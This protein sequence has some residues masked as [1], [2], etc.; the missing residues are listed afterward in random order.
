MARRKVY[1]PALPPAMKKARAAAKRALKKAPATQAATVALV[2]SVIARQD[3]TKF[4]SELVSDRVGHN[5][6][7]GFADIIN[8]LPKLVQDQGEGA[9]YE[10]LG[11][12]VSTR[13]HE[14]CI[15]VCMA[16]VERSNNIIVHMWILTNKS[17]KQFN[18]LDATN[19]NLARLL[20]LGSTAQ[21][22]SYNGYAQDAMLPINSSQFTVLHHR[23]FFLGKNTGTLQ[24]STT[25]GNQPS[26]THALNKRFTF[27][28]KAPQTLV[29]EQD[30]NTPRTVYYPSNWAPFCVIGYQHVSNGD[31]DYV[32]QDINVTA[33]ANLWFDDA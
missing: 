12:K 32:N 23:K 33:R 26:F 25:A 28:L 21:Y 20:M 15:D 13:K 4:R 1:G 11:R 19:T 24:D 16:D 9:I 5:S 27:T 31:P 2:K 10:R 18:R 6:Q 3:E 30:N 29:Y 14:F 8:C 7:I 17:V 22:Q